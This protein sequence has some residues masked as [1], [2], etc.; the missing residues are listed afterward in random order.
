MTPDDKKEKA[1]KTQVA[2]KMIDLKKETISLKQD[3][4]ETN[5]RVAK[6][7][8]E[9]AEHRKAINQVRRSLWEYIQIALGHRKDVEKLSHRVDD[10]SERFDK[11]EE[12]IDWTTKLI[13][14]VVVTGI[15]TAGF[16]YLLNLL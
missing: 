5:K 15:V 2:K 13:V 9:S 16:V 8:V 1:Y 10:T 14:G 6:L 12:T 4:S 7:E 11:I 3:L